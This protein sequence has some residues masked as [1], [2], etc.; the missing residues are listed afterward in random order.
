[1]KKI[2]NFYRNLPIRFKLFLVYSSILVAAALLTVM[3][4]YSQVHSTIEANIESELTNTTATIQNMVQASANTSIKNYLRAVAEKN[5]E[6][7][8]DIYR[9]HRAGLMTEEEAKA[10]AR[11]VLFSQ[12]IGKTGYIY[13]ANSKGI[14]IV[15]PNPG[16]SGKKYLHHQFVKEQ[17]KRKEGYLEYEWE[18]PGENWK[19]QKALYMTYFKPWDWIISVSTYRDE[20]K[21]LVNVNDFRDS[22]LALKFGKTGYSYVL[23]SKGNVIVHPILQGNVYDVTD[24]KGWTFVR[25]I[26]AQKRGKIIYSWKNPGEEA[27][28]EKLVIFNYI[29][30]YDWIV[31]STSYLEEVYAPLKTARNVVVITIFGILLLGLPISFWISASIIRPLRSLMDR[32]SQGASGDLS[33]RMPIKSADEIGQLTGYFNKFM[34]KLEISRDHLKAEIDERKQTEEALRESEKK[35]RTILERIKEGYFEVD[36]NG[37]FTFFNDSML[38]ILGFSEDE[39][40]RMNLRELIDKKNRKKVIRIFSEVKDLGDASNAAGWELIKKDHSS[41]F[42]E[43]SVSLIA[44]K[45]GQPVGFRGVLRD[46]TE[47]KNAEKESKRLEQEILNISERERQRIGR[48]LHDDLCPQLIGIEVLSKVLKKRLERKGVAEADDAA[49]ISAFIKDSINKT[50]RLSRG[51]YPV[52]L[53]DRGLDSSLAEMALYIKDVFGVECHFRSDIPSPFQ[54]DTTAANHIYYIVHEA[55]HNAVKHSKSK[56]IFIILS[57]NNGKVILKIRDDGQGIPEAVDSRGMGLRLMN[58]RANKIGAYLDISKDVEGGT[59]VTI[60]FEME[61]EEY[62]S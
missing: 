12:T 28:R 2:A 29:E 20:F 32:F 21:D 6:I 58:Y 53:T 51:L 15:H 59:L 27:Y 17:I 10:Q 61:K 14:A 7:T 55:V 16:V 1:M 18:N 54:N 11:G 43:I 24:A 30:E 48:D 3:L 50:R 19:K 39:M 62:V 42:C 8:E 57:A 47:H 5:R 60:E 33:V 13:C 31:A 34:E 37:N 35:Y 26:C 38:K 45:E 22:I 40:G 25:D 52:N 49:K 36:L 23:D 56:N 41:C 4:I 9:R 44:D 46:V